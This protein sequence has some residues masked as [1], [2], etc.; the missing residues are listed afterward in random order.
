M[1]ILLNAVLLLLNYNFLF[2]LFP[3][4]SSGTVVYPKSAIFFPFFLW[5]L[6]HIKAL[7]WEMGPR[8]LQQV[9]NMFLFFFFFCKLFCHYFNSYL[10][11]NTFLA[12]TW[13]V[14]KFT[15]CACIS[16]EPCLP[17]V[18]ARC[19]QLSFGTEN[20]GIA[21]I[22]ETKLWLHYISAYDITIENYTNIL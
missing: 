8:V 11:F 21:L 7:L 9:F 4:L 2:Y 1:L 20:C 18:W 19:F 13:A 10:I 22:N 12:I 17:V 3:I 16:G 5:F 6:Y 15:G 14:V